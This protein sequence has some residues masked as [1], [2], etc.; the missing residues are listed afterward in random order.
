MAHKKGVGSSDNGRDSKSKRLGVKLYGGQLARSGNIIV[1]QRGTRFHPGRHVGMGKDFTIY[2]LAEG[3]IEFKKGRKN[4]TFIS[5][6]PSEAVR[7]TIAAMPSEPIRSKVEPAAIIEPVTKQVA[8][9]KPVT[10]E[11]KDTGKPPADEVVATESKVS[12]TPEAAK[13]KVKD[14]QPKTKSRAKKIK[15]DNLKVIEGVGPKLESILKEAGI[16]DLHILA[17]TEVLRLR[18]ILESAGNRYK[19]FNPTT[20]PKQ[21]TLAAEGKMDELKAYQ[22]RLDGGVEKG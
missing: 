18:E 4:R 15:E 11:Q 14:A 16:K 22:D 8:P 6:V 1:R 7:E 9:E 13:E 3:V 2:A 21:A 10:S 17:S 12:P 20:W 19:M 5:V